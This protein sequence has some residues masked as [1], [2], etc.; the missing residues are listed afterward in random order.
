MIEGQEDVGWAQWRAL[1]EAVERLGF[2][3]LYRSD[4]YLSVDDRRERGSLDAWGTICALAALTERIRL[5]TL[6]SPAS[7]RHPSV[8][9]KLATTADH[10]SGGRID[11]GIGAGW[12]ESEHA[13]YGFPFLP[14]RERL[15]VL[16]EQLAVIAGSWA[17]GPLDFDGEHYRLDA[18]DA[19]PKP[20]QQPRPPLILGGRGGP[21]S[22]RLAAAHADE[23]NTVH[24]TPEICAQVRAGLDEACRS[25]G[26]D[27]ATLPLSLMNGGLIGADRDELR[28]RGRR[29]AAWRGEHPEDIDAHLAELART[30]IVGT[31]DEVLARLRAYEAA[32]VTR[33]MIQHH[34][35]DDLDAL[36]LW[37]ERVLP[38]LAAPG[39]AG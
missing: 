32:G 2:E 13:R 10:I 3:G 1:A 27:P 17:P 36:A 23:Y 38:G 31:P 29:L 8:L 4:H 7:F 14:V 19:L 12:W 30:W 35:H 22:L 34:L 24:A 15:D 20:L 16:A 26:R 6:V 5:G 9:A 18:L 37:A 33:V 11:L 25:A 21:R 28:E 39:T